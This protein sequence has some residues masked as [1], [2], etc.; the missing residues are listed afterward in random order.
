MRPW[1]ALAAFPNNFQPASWAGPRARQFSKRDDIFQQLVGD[2]LREGL[3]GQVITVRT[4]GQDGSIDGYLPGSAALLPLFPRLTGPVIVECKDNDDSLPKAAENISSAWSK[5]KTKLTAQAAAGWPGLYEPWKDAQS[6]LYITSALVPDVVKRQEIARSI[7]TFFQHLRSQSQSKVQQV[8]LVDWSDVRDL[9]DR[10][11]RLADAWLGVGLRKL[12]GHGE[13]VTALATDFRRYLL[14][15]NLPFVPPD[16]N[17][18][19]HPD[20]LLE[21]V[22]A[23]ADKGGV[24]L[25]GAGGVGKTRTLLEVGERAHAQ[26]WR[27]LHAL[28]G[29][30]A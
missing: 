12:R 22:I 7:E 18:A 21:Q 5:V 20:R 28:H 16:P 2:A 11:P 8:H 13:H 6:Y 14:P 30:P 4:A 1:G 29:E 19:A 23:R 10:W 25:T 3:P 15:A 27:V 9:L 17:D 26:G 24:L